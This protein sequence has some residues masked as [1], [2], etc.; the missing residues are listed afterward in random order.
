MRVVKLG[1]TKELPGGERTAHRSFLLEKIN[2]RKFK[3]INQVD[4]S[5]NIPEQKDS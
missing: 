5:E 3:G 1:N 2:E 4:I